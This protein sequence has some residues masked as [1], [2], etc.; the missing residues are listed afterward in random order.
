[1]REMI[2]IDYS[3]YLEEDNSPETIKFRRK[4]RR[5]YRMIKIKKIWQ[6]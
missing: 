5:Q 3:P 4:I 2:K 1:M 6:T